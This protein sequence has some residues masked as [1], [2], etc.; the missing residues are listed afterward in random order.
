[1][2]TTDHRWSVLRTQSSVLLGPQVV[3]RMRSEPGVPPGDGEQRAEALGW[4]CTTEQN[5]D[6]PKKFPLRGLEE[7]SGNQLRSPWQIISKIKIKYSN[8]SAFRYIPKRLIFSF[9]FILAAFKTLAYNFQKRRLEWGGGG[10]AAAERFA[11]KGRILAAWILHPWAPRMGLCSPSSP[12]VCK[13]HFAINIIYK[14]V[15]IRM[16]SLREK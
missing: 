12:W 14:M 7:I 15:K 3:L 1:M 10:G 9:N 5:D 4:E 2:G 13:Q 11:H 16:F 8:I 6:Q